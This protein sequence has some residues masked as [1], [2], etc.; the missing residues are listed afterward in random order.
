MKWGYSLI[1]I[2]G[3]VQR[4]LDASPSASFGKKAFCVGR[5]T[6]KTPVLT[7]C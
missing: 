5:L 1:F 2:N 6:N 7:S 4:D 3:T